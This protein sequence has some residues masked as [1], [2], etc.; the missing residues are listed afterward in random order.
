MEKGEKFNSSSV[1]TELV[2]LLSHY[3]IY[4][5]QQT[6]LIH[7]G[8]DNSSSRGLLLF[9]AKRPQFTWESTG[10]SHDRPRIDTESRGNLRSIDTEILNRIDQT[11]KPSFAQDEFEQRA[12]RSK[13]DAVL[14]ISDTCATLISQE[15]ESTHELLRDV[16]TPTWLSPSHY[17]SLVSPN[18]GLPAA[19]FLGICQVRS[20]IDL[21]VEK[22][23]PPLSMYEQVLMVGHSRGFPLLSVSTIIM[24][25]GF[26]Y[27]SRSNQYLV[28]Q[29]FL[30]LPQ[31]K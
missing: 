9:Q 20:Y 8:I 5:G 2:K 19:N 14:A 7:S 17:S 21:H 31:P 1:G 13:K 16:A 4:I 26:L 24:A 12:V 6:G 3:I 29:L 15:C 28:C 18:Q 25:D 22:E 30:L 27:G 23:K 10:Y 11:G